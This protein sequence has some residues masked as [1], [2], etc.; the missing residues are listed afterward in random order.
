MLVAVAGELDEAFQ[1][2][3]AF[4]FAGHGLIA[5][6]GGGDEP[7]EAELEGHGFAKFFIPHDAVPLVRGSLRDPGNVV[8]WA[9]RM[10]PG[11]L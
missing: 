8:K 7:E 5:L 1:L 4:D 2:L 3:F 6:V 9:Y 11:I 10:F